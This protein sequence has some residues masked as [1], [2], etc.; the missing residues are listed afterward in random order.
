MNNL[1]NNIETIK[2]MLDTLP[3]NNQKNIDKYLSIVNEKL[4]VYNVY[5]KEIL[6]EI[7]FRR[8]KIKSKINS[9]D[10]KSLEEEI[11][12]Y[13]DVLYLTSKYNTPYEKL[14]LDKCIYNISFLV[15]F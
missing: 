3:K 9:V 8:N 14:G 2:E 11:T 15:I 6:N 5:K 1:L 12:D 13:E 7:K 4:E 10:T